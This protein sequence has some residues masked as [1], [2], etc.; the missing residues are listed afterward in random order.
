MSTFEASC[1]SVL[2]LPSLDAPVSVG[3]VHLHLLAVIECAHEEAS[4]GKP[5]RNSSLEESLSEL[6]LTSVVV[7]S[8]CRQIDCE[9]AGNALS[10][11]VCHP[12]YQPPRK[13]RNGLLMIGDT[14]C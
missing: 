13:D 5:P 4:V 2:E 1:D 11:E 12:V 3:N 10:H 14:K 7:F 8:G 6:S 9:E